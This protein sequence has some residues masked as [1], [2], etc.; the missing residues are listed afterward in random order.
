MA[1]AE[2]VIDAAVARADEFSYLAGEATAAIGKAG[3]KVFINPYPL[4]V[5]KSDF[6]AALKMPDPDATPMPFYDAPTAPYPV[7]P[8]L[9]DLRTVDIPKFDAAPTIKTTGL[10][11]QKAPSSVMPDWNEANPALHVDEIYNELANLAAPIL[12]DVDLPSISPLNLPTM[13]GFDLP[14]YEVIAAPEAI[15]EAMD[16][17]TYLDAKY[18][19]MLP[20]AQAFIDD[21]VDK[22]IAK[23]APEFQEQRQ[24]IHEQLMAGLDGKVLPDQFEAALYTRARGRAEAD[25]RAAEE[26]IL[27]NSGVRGF[28]I[29]PSAITSALNK[30]STAKAGGLATQ[31]T[32]IYLE[33]RRSE[34]QHLQFV[35][36][37]ISQQVQSVRAS[38]VQM[39]Q[40][41][42]STIQ[43]SFTMAD[44]I[45]NKLVIR[46]EHE[47]SRHE[48]SLAVMKAL[49]EQY[50]VQLKAALSGLEAYKLELQSLELQKNVEFKAIEGAKL[51]IES[52]Q[53]LVTR[54]SA[55]VDAIAKRAVV[56]ELKIKEYSIRADVFKTNVQARLAAFEAY[57]AAID[58]DKAKLQ[59][60]LA[61]LD[62]YNAQIKATSLKLEAETKI[63]DADVKVNLSKLTQFSNQLDAYKTA[64]EVA[65]QKFTA[66]AEIKKMGL[67]I[68]KTNLQ[69]NIA[70]YEGEL[71]LDVAWVETQIEAF[72]ANSDKWI[73]SMQLEQK[74]ADLD[75]QKAIAIASSYSNI[76]SASAQAANG[77]ASIAAS[78]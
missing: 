52:Q 35:M 58:G 69:A 66:G 4:N 26:A 51:K 48:F 49:N 36:T 34:V 12:A 54:Y 6:D 28:L 2:L 16:Y 70:A 18:K 1:I 47:R 42:I 30:N 61:K 53:L 5:D 38:I 64:S 7:S 46:F 25:F 44:A 32:E 9:V 76:A 40:E 24:A 72:K 37:A 19:A 75:I 13:P 57:K 39:T 43:Q 27:A 15:P 22:R 71:K 78:E 74:Y 11:T 67:D 65:L 10:F 21:F 41:A 17:A 31:S 29:P 56:D 62:V 77:S 60:E 45:T 20:E 33:R 68:Y 59:G 73:A 23:Y 3:R 63:L 14:S 8:T 50:E 55:M